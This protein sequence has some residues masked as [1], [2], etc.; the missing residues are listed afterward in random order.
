[1]REVSAALPG[2]ASFVPGHPIAGK[3]KSGPEAGSSDL[4]HGRQILLTPEDTHDPAVD[5]VRALWEAIGGVVECMDASVHD[6]MFARTSHVPHLMAFAAARMNPSLVDQS[7]PEDYRIFLRIGASNPKMWADVFV[8]NADFVLEGLR[9]V[10]DALESPDIASTQAFR[11]RLRHSHRHAWECGS[12]AEAYQALALAA[13]HACVA[14]ACVLPEAEHYVGAGFM[15]FT[16]PATAAL[17]EARP[18]IE[19]DKAVV[20]LYVD[21]LQSLIPL[22]R[23]G[24]VDALERTL[25][26]AQK[27]AVQLLSRFG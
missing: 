24:D 18:C 25:G 17:E 19:R 5:R 14:S 10:F 21:A 15:D 22:I 27:A 23:A 2:H 6:R 7:L 8:Y 13:A 9:A 16:F 11:T 3:E 26:N 20:S 12:G 1:M 4:F